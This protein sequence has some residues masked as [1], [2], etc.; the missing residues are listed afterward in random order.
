MFILPFLG[1]HLMLFIVTYYTPGLGACGGYNSDSDYVVA[2]AAETFDNYP[3][4]LNFG[5][6]SM[7]RKL[8]AVLFII[9]VLEP[10][11]ISR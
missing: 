2:V 1:I 4:V 10:T 3:Y 8:T 5:Q 6:S 11:Q 7:A 9:V